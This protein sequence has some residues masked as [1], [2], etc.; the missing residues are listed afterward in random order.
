MGIYN[1]KSMKIA[2]LTEMG[3]CGKIPDT[4]INMRTEFS[5]MC[6]LDADH[7]PIINYNT[8]VGY[9]YVM[10][11]FPK[12][13]GHNKSIDGI[14]LID[15]KN[16]Y[17]NLFAS[18]IV[19]DLKKYNKKVCSVQEG[20]T[21]YSNDFDLQDQFN[22]YNQIAECDIIFSH[23]EYD[24]KWYRGLYPGKRVEVMPTLMIETLIKDIVSYST[25]KAIIGGNFCRWYGGFQSYLVAQ[26]FE[27]PIWV[28]TSHASQPGE[29]QV[30][31]ILPRVMWFD[32][33]KTLSTF[34]YAVHMMPTIAAGTFSLNCAYLGIPCIGNKEVD[35]QRI[36]FPD[37]SVSSE[38]VFGARGLAK[39]LK[40]EP[41]FY[42]T[43]SELAKEN[44]RKYFG[45]EQWK[46]YINT[47]LNE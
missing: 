21:W 28:Q 10:I 40:E 29:E 46:N 24:T 13:G 33:I 38:N 44:Y 39:M 15:K 23:N 2:F 37:L 45:V 47:I 30:V 9:D 25:P 14:T 11:I 5:W 43:C 8:V 42:Q 34:K 41:R 3:F 20:P 12:G 1:T 22:L 18:T 32:W 27:V 26:E 4:H 16:P 7:F 17:S 6:A 36:C 31:N 35:T 19:S